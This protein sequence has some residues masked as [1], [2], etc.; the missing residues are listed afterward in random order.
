MPK[1]T[2]PENASG[3]LTLIETPTESSKGLN[4]TTSLTNL[5]SKD[6]RAVLDLV[7]DLKKL[8]LSGEIDLPQMVVCGQQSAGKSS[9]LEALTDLSF[10]RDDDVCTR[11]AT[12][13]H[14]RRSDSVS[15]SI[16]II[17]GE[18]RSDAEKARLAAFQ[19]SITN[20]DQL[21][22]IMEEAMVVMGIDKIKS[23][24]KTFS[25]DVLSVEIEGPGRP[26]LTLVD[27][28]GL[29]ATATRGATDADVAL[30]AA[31][32]DRYI[33]QPRTICLAVVAGGSD[34]ATQT[35]LNK[36]K[37]VD[38]K[39]N[40]T[41]GIITKPDRIESDKS[42]QTY[43]ELT[44]NLDPQCQLKLGWHVIK[45]RTAKESDFTLEERKASES[46][47]LA[48]SV[49]K[50]LPPDQVGIDTLRKR[51]SLLLFEHIRQEL[52]KLRAEVDNKLGAC[53]YN[54]QLM[55]KGRSS[56]RQCLT[57]LTETSMQYY[58]TCK[59][60]VD[61]HYEGA[62]FHK[63]E[64]CP[65]KHWD[66]ELKSRRLRA[67]I[68][69]LNAA[70][71]TDLRKN[72]RKYDISG[73]SEYDLGE[74]KP[75]GSEKQ[76]EDQGP[77]PMT[78]T[79]ALEWVGSKMEAS[80]GKELIGNFNPLLIG[81]L[82]WEQ[83]S[84]WHELAI[85]HMERVADSCS[86]FLKDLLQL[87]CPD[88]VDE[89]VWEMIDD[90]LKQ[91]R[92]A[93]EEELDKIIED[94]QDHPMNYC[95]P[96]MESYACEEALIS[97]MSIYKLKQ[98]VFID[99][100][101]VQV[102][103]RHIVR[104]LEKIFSPLFVS[105]LSEDEVM[106]LAGEPLEAQEERKRLEIKIKNCSFSSRSTPYHLVIVM[107]TP[108]SPDLCGT[109]TESP[110]SP[111]P[112]T[113]DNTSSLEGLQT[114]EQRRVL[115][116]V[117]RVRKCGLEGT[118]SLPQIVVCGDQSAGKS[119]VLEALTEIPFPRNDNLC[120]RHATEI[121]LRNAA[122]DSITIK[123]IP[124]PER[125]HTEQADIKSFE[126]SIFNFAELPKIMDKA[127]V[128]MGIGSAEPDPNV[129][130]RA[131]ARDVL[132]IEIAGP[133]RPQLTLVDIPGLIGAET[134]ATTKSDIALVAEIT[135]HYIQQP[136][137]ICL[138][139]ISAA[140]DYANQTILER[141][142]E[143]DPDGDRTLGVITKP[144]MP[145]AGS[146]SEQAYIELARNED[147]FFK[148]G[149][150]VVKNRKFDERNSS[151]QEQ[152]IIESTFFRT[153]N[154]KSLPK[155]CVG[156]DTL[157]RRLSVLLFEHVKKE[158]PKLREELETALEDSQEQL[159]Q[160][161]TARSTGQDC[162]AYLAQLSQDYYELCKAGVDGH[163]EGSYFHTDIDSEF[164]ITSPSTLRRTR[165]LVQSL[166]SKFAD[167]MRVSGHKYQI[168]LNSED[169]DPDS[170]ASFSMGNFQPK[171]SGQPEK[172]N[173]AAAMSWVRKALIRNRG[174]ELIGNFNPLL[175]GELFW[176]LSERWQKLAVEHVDQVSKI[177]NL[178]LKTLLADKCPEDV[179]RRLWTSR[180][181]QELKNRHQ[182]AVKELGL[183]MKDHKNFPINYNH[184]YTD[185][186]AK[187]R[188]DR[189]KAA[190]TKAI[191]G[192]TSSD[193]TYNGRDTNTTTSVN[194][195]LAIASYSSSVDP[196]MDNFSCEEALD[197]LLAIYKVSQKTFVANVTM[198][199][200]ERHIVRG[201]EKI[202][203]TVFVSGLDL[204]Q[205]FALASEPSS[206]M[207]LRARLE[208][209]IRKLEEG[210]EIFRSVM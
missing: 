205:A 75:E 203:D 36:V 19:A 164:A 159:Q 175:I 168:E 167:T 198:Q 191:E 104:G 157:R 49:F 209:Q 103:E 110:V 199:V 135:K 148:L 18:G 107:S 63:A 151:L 136:R 140:T 193:T 137:T 158:L 145:P 188:Q 85:I 31:I 105:E 150:H 37:K 24:G 116:T 134:K 35:I 146:G 5:E 77:L 93:A 112:G 115:D 74:E 53:E 12:V 64:G 60:A 70:F 22:A 189:S 118:V 2:S 176:E 50:V 86:C 39:G 147:I 15:V 117:A 108:G 40:R 170:E 144:D 127:M 59:A 174:K 9:L 6:Q 34:Y 121:S 201:L 83:S 187:R 76:Q 23:S 20:L 98:K 51:L 149:W 102:I 43:L 179:E 92:Q 3:S 25:E 190:L 71:E 41:L 91:R 122:I 126:Q 142:R 106:S 141:V 120:T 1:A 172:L 153:S 28:P 143:V 133:G 88:D 162:K 125:P 29:I 100:V 138:A 111:I 62:Y 156:I 38:P 99:V 197:C 33:S 55:G 178:F 89:R 7:A 131:F 17:A 195:Q 16:K 13:I 181:Q 10:P 8:G 166:N 185:T 52:P 46:E 27:I 163:Y 183:L 69:S 208:D 14:I 68:Q 61:G 94:L 207:S 109:P 11:Y 194:I 171:K 165:A 132:S 128:V 184:Y 57:F 119:S 58:Q 67:M 155:E 30:V 56:A 177:C 73:L 79:A 42:L 48:S 65:L 200:V 47:W 82:F 45:N 154:W 206:S 169:D 4:L 161:G 173:N 80:R 32:T 87:R 84:K 180:I 101:T 196:N 123:V 114:E 66:E 204:E 21:P 96:D 72:G 124:D 90:Q 139:V 129:K 95:D 113:L 210:Q 97:L 186:I 44:Q 54:L 81:E 152:N 202:F 78:K 192:A 182:A 130:S 26:Q 160:L